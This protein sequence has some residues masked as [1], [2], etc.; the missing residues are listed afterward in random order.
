MIWTK[1][2]GKPPFTEIY[3]FII[4]LGNPPPK[5]WMISTWYI[6]ICGKQKT[7]S[8]SA[9][10]VPTTSALTLSILRLWHLLVP[11]P[12]TSM[13]W[14]PSWEAKKLMFFFFFAKNGLT[15]VL[16]EEHVKIE[17]M[18]AM[19]TWLIDFFKE[20]FLAVQWR[21][22]QKPHIFSERHSLLEPFGSLCWTLLL[23]SSSKVHALLAGPDMQCNLTTRACLNMFN[24]LKYLL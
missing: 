1:K 18:N 11:N 16:I 21:L 17:A 5:G 9:A 20:T 2:N 13:S 15:G 10:F 12:I 6:S 24:H 19:K 14:K 8:F 4:W 3:D 23:S 7:T 22:Q